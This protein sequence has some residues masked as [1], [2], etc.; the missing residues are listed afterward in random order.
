MKKIYSGEFS[1]EIELYFELLRVCLIKY[2][3]INFSKF[4][5]KTEI[6]VVHIMLIKHELH[7][8]LFIVMLYNFHRTETKKESSLSEF[9][10]ADFFFHKEN[11]FPLRS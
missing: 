5:N 7:N 1:N 11:I 9:K 8:L 10:T 4:T 3:R 2:Q 6:T